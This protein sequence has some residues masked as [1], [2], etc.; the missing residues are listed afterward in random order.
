MKRLRS[1]I[2]FLALLVLACALAVHM[3]RNWYFFV[4]NPFDRK[5]PFL[6]PYTVETDRNNNVY[7]IDDQ[8]KRIIKMNDE[9]EVLFVLLGRSRGMDGFY[10]AD[11]IAADEN[12]NI[13][14]VNSIENVK[15]G[16]AGE[17]VIQKYLPD[18]AFDRE[19]FR[20]N[21]SEEDRLTRNRY[22]SSNISV[23]G[24]KVS[25]FLYDR[26]R[27][28]LFY[29]VDTAGG[30]ARELFRIPGEA[31]FIKFT[32]DAKGDIYLTRLDGMFYKC[33]PD[34]DLS[35]ISLPYPADEMVF[36]WDAGS[37]LNGSVYVSNL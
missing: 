28:S 9:G 31:V 19:V 33:S 17:Q 3:N 32:K 37:S 14:I 18:G 25:F 16:Y 5:Y 13:Y 24:D 29:E 1:F 6:S 27:G 36:P 26:D 22:I 10:R 7:L 23:S 11:D 34:G 15:D 12:N 20:I 35:V 2:I 21:R 30:D 8:L 4:K